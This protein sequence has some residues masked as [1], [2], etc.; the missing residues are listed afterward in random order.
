MLITLMLNLFIAC[1]SNDTKKNEK[2]TNIVKSLEQRIGL[3]EKKVSVT[4]KEIEEKQS[5]NKSFTEEMVLLEEND[6]KLK[7]NIDTF[8]MKLESLEGN[9]KKK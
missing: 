2:I 5:Q 7:T 1:Q 8:Q 3:L 4:K 6:K 9:I